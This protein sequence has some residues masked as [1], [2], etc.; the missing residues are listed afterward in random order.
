M[1][2]NQ[3]LEIIFENLKINGFPLVGYTLA[4]VEWIKDSLGLEGKV[5]SFVSMGV[6]IAIG[7]LYQLSLG[8]VVGFSS[9]VGV[10]V[11]GTSLG[12]LA[13]GVYKLASRFLK[14]KEV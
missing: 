14:V 9:W 11:F 7:S 13:S 5:V 12:L 2:F 6:G 10:F 3:V 1:D 4:L 8:P